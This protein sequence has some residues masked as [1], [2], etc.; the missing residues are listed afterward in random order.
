MAVLQLR[1]HIPI[2][3]PARREAADGSESD[4]RV[5]LGFEP[6][7][8]SKRCNVDF[9]EKWH[10]D[11]YYRHETLK[12]MK[13]E[14]V[15]AFP[16]VPYWDLS[17]KD[18]LSTISG[19]YGAYIIP[20]VFGILLRYASDMWPEPEIQEPLSV[21]EIEKLDVDRLLAGP[22]VEEI[23]A[24][25]DII[26]KEWGKIHGYLNWQGV[27]NNA[28]HLRKQE[29]FLDI[30]D[31]PEFSRQLFSLITEVLIRLAKMVQER[32][33]NS[34]FYINHFVAGNCTINMISPDAYQEFLF[35]FDRKIAE[36]FERFGVHTCNWDVTP[37]IEVLKALPKV[38]Y[39]DMGMMSDMVRVR[40]NFPDA[41]RAVLYH[42][43]SLAEKNMD[44][45]KADM[46]KIYSGIGPCDLVAADIQW[47]TPDKIVNDLL[48]ICADLIL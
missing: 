23:F 11:P 3:S 26:E 39:L 48:R 1:N 42:P 45:I 24:Q 34:G 30:V 18:D 5:S 29:V 47:D 35:D 14:L 13:K 7:W 33:R 21:K 19:C 20:R 36:S 8:Y 9:S 44:G 27:L 40:N 6:K 38:G 4:M 31:R 22:F 43:G 16:A 28:F 41:R 17:Y 37:Y 12:V 25:M 46:K 32:Q 10:V 2:A 15:K